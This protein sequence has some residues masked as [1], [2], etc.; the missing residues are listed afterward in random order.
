MLRVRRGDVEDV[1]LGSLLSG[2]SKGA[3]T[4]SDEENTLEHGS[5]SVPEHT[6]E[7]SS[8]EVPQHHSMMYPDSD[9]ESARPPE[10]G[11]T[12]HRFER[13]Q[14]LAR[15]E[16]KHGM[17]RRFVVAIFG[18]LSV[19]AP[20][21]VM[22]IHPSQVKTLATAS[23]AVIVFALILAWKSSARVETLL[24]TTAAYAAVLVVFVGVKN[25]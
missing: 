3:E 24:A 1:L 5:G 22:A 12:K 14:R 2:L 10:R 13:M 7:L 8:G 17:Q 16:R 15:L 21:L 19:I 4:S 20:M 11:V 25:N 6:S 23:V 18:G 9:V